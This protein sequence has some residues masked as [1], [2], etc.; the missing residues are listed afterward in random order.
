MKY[1]LR[2]GNTIVYQAGKEEVVPASEMIHIFRKEFPEQVRG[3][4][5]LNAVL[6]GLKQLEDLDTAEL[7]ASKIAACLGLFYERNGQTP[8]GDFLGNDED[9]GTFAQE[10][11]PR[12]G[13]RCSQWVFSEK[14]FTFASKQQLR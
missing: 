7:F 11:A 6:N 4:P 14:H 13:K 1:Y 5:D 3:F 9:E 12:N 2:P 8:T 10:I